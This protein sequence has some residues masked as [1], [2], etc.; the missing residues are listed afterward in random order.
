MKAF[1]LEGSGQGLW[2]WDLESGQV[3]CS[4]LG[5]S[6]LGHDAADIGGIRAWFGLVHRHDRGDFL[7]RLASHLHGHGSEFEHRFRIRRGDGE[8]LSIQARG[9]A[10]LRDATG[11][12]RR[13]I[14]TFFDFDEEEHAVLEARIATTVFSQAAEGIMVT[15]A[16]NRIVKVNRAFTEVT[17]YTEAEVLGRNPNILSSGRQCREFY[18]AM[19]QQ[20]QANG[21]WRGEIWNRRKDGAFYAEWLSISVMRDEAG[22]TVRHVAIF[23]D[24]TSQKKKEDLIRRHAYY[25][26]LTELPNRR[27]ALDRLEQAVLQAGRQ[28]REFALLFVDLD[29]F[30]DIND[31]LGHAIGDKV[32][33][34]VAA[35]LRDCASNDDTVARLAGDEFLVLAHPAQRDGATAA[36]AERI[37]RSLSEPVRTDVGEIALSASVGIACYPDD[38]RDAESL[39]KGADRAMFAA[40]EDGRNTYRFFTPRLHEE[41]RERVEVLMRLRH[42]IRDQRF[43]AHFQPIFDLRSGRM[44]EAE[45]LIRWSLESGGFMPPDR[46]IP[47]AE[48][49]DLIVDI[50]EWMF[51]RML[52]VLHRL[53][54]LDAL[55][56]DFR[57]TLNL[58]PRHLMTRETPQDWLAQFAAAGVKPSAL[59]LEITEGLLLEQSPDILRKLTTFA[60]AGVTLAIDDF[61]TGYSAMSYLQKFPIHYVKIDRSFIREIGASQRDRAITEAIVVMAQKLG[62]KTIAEGIETERQHDLLRE[63]GCDLGQGYLFARP[64][65]EDAFIIEAQRCFRPKP[66]MLG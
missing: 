18:A 24:I 2:D 34:E 65:S 33:L 56:N 11:K 61:G 25:D 35:R 37:I 44:A 22:K 17:G 32:L 5:L 16:Q 28:G 15:D 57:L 66:A 60:D 29:R 47:L 51:R 13:F 59:T 21:H 7:R 30:K 42:A 4:H 39:L 64:M 20:L 52:N 10:T 19:W 8:W 14:G 41:A 6:L 27:L 23:T 9:M 45:A 40:K 55:P 36:L 54:V 62:L 1:A 38:G 43:A 12:P 49:T 63:M 46:F 31:T 53:Q 48:N 50:G 3:H 26:A 58:S